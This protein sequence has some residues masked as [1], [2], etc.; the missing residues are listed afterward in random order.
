MDPQTGEYTSSVPSPTGIAADVPLVSHGEAQARQLADY[1]TATSSPSI[2]SSP[3]G[4]RTTTAGAAISDNDAG[5]NYDDKEAGENYD[6]DDDEDDGGDGG[7]PAAVA[8]AASQRPFEKPGIRIDRIY[9]S[10]FVRCLQT[11]APTVQRLGE[12]RQRQRQRHKR[13]GKG[14]RENDEGE[15]GGEERGSSSSSS[16]SR[17]SYGHVEVRGEYG[18]G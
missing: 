13:G 15:G 4:C 6:D 12:L 5:W 7:T 11:L 8:A 2:S 14:G 16:T 9:S 1:L 18:F 3:S 17:G 10:P